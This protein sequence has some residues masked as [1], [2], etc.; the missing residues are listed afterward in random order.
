MAT[1]LTYAEATRFGYEVHLVEPKTDADAG[2]YLF[3]C[4]EPILGYGR[5][6]N[7]QSVAVTP[8][9]VEF[10]YLCEPFIPTVAGTFRIW[11]G[12]AS[13]QQQNTP[14][15]LIGRENG[16]ATYDGCHESAARRALPPTETEMAEYRTRLAEA[17]VKAE[18]RSAALRA[19][20]E[21]AKEAKNV[22]DKI[23]RRQMVKW[24]LT[25]L[26]LLLGSVMLAQVYPSLAAILI[27][28]SLV[29]GVVTF[30]LTPSPQAGG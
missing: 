13:E 16:S 8:A 29:A 5:D 17:A 11:A 12:L 24:G 22:L 28:G 20:R 21:A 3:W 1:P 4:R 30:R 2:R 15:R 18:E 6:L 27:L 14:C 26:A 7:Q 10:V 25:S 9:N 23:A 19:K